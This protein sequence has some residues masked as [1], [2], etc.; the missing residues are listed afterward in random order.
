MSYFGLGSSPVYG[1]SAFVP[2][3]NPST[4]QLLCELDSTQLGTV[5]LA[6]N[7]K[8]LVNVTYILG[9]STGQQ[10]QIGTCAST[11]LNSGK[12]EY[13]PRTLAGQSAQFVIRHE[14]FKDYRIRARV[15]S[16]SQSI[17]EAGISAVALE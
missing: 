13:Y 4:S 8:L 17:S 1:S 15:F 2:L 6:P 5:N 11:A 12:D 3:T 16:T 7:Q 9:G 14:L 10:F